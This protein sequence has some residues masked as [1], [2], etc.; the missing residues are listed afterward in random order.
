MDELHELVDDAGFPLFHAHAPE[1]V[2]HHRRVA[3]DT[4]FDRPFGGHRAGTKDR[5][6]GSDARTVSTETRSDFVVSRRSAPRARARTSD[7]CIGD[8][9][10]VLRWVA[11]TLRSLPAH[12]FLE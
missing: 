6:R 2:D 5:A 7:T 10:S 4:A 11:S 8:D 3:G 9:E 12:F 1:D